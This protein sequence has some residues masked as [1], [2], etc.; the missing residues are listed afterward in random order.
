MRRV[1]IW[2]VI[3]GLWLLLVLPALA[4]SGGVRVE[5]PDNLLG[6]QANQVR[7]AAQRLADEGAEV[8][9]LAAGPSAGSDATSADQYL[10][11]FLAQNNLAASSRQINPNQVVFYVARDARR[12][13]LLY[14]SRWKQTLDPVFQSIQDQQMNPRFAS[15]DVAGGM[16]AGIDAARTTIN[17]P[18]SPLVYVLGGALV[19]GVIALITVPMLQKRRASATALET[20]RERM[21]TARQAAGAAISDVA[22]VAEQ[23]QAKA[24][25]DR[26]SYSQANI[27][28]LQSL[29]A[30]G[31]QLFQEAQDLFSTADDQIELK[32]NPTAGDYEAVAAQYERAQNL[33]Q[34]ANSSIGE[35]EA[36]R[37]Q[38]DAQ[39][40]PSTGPTTRL[41]E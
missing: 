34:Q 16:I 33:A 7:E 39:G 18:T 30:K 41:R 14:G 8:I 5:D 12:T 13:S 11:D 17:P 27:E 4:Q 9:V 6:A 15:G 31:T 25:Y 10:S 29:Q 38:L 37:A 28:R 36:L 40:S 21:R 3:L 24:Q 2:S 26:I 20:A 35:A 22:G 32:A 23:A 19:L 1:H